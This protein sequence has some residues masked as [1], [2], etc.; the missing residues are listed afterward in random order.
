[1]R[2]LFDIDPAKRRRTTFLYE[3]NGREDKDQVILHTE[4]DVEP[5]L[6]HND[7]KRNQATGRWGDLAHVASIDQNTWLELERSGI[8]YDDKALDRWLNDPDHRRYR[9]KAGRL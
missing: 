4:Q 6:K 8:A 3:D 1:M 9:T 7:F 5:L 2:R